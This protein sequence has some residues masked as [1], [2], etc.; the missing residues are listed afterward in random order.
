[1]AVL[2]AVRSGRIPGAVR[3]GRNWAIPRASAEAYEPRPY[4]FRHSGSRRRDE[5]E[6]EQRR[7]TKRERA[8]VRREIAKK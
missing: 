1:V 7:R 8:K 5:S 6:A 4:V 2:Y 3:F